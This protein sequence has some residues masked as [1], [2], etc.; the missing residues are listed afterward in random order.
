MNAE[1]R[2]PNRLI[3]EKSPYLHQ[4][5]YNPVDWYPWGEEAFEKAK[6]EN[7]PIFLSIGYSTC[8]WCH[9]MEEESFEDLKVAERLNEVFVCIKVD[10]EERPDIDQIY[11]NACQMMTG[12]GGW[13]LTIIM[14]PDKTPFF[15]G[16]YF[17]KKSKYGRIGLLELIERVQ[18]IWEHRRQDCVNA[19]EKITEALRQEPAQPAGFSPG[20]LQMKDAFLHLQRTFDRTYGG[21]GNAPK[22]PTVQNLFFLLR[23]WKTT[24]ESD[25][26]YMVEKTLQE[27]RKGG[28][29][30]HI[31]SGFHRYSTGRDW[32]L[33]HFEKMLYDQAMLAMV[34]CEAY[35][36]TEKCEYADT[37]REIFTY[38][39]R[40][41][42]SPLGGFFSAED[43]DSEGEEGKFYLWSLNEIQQILGAEEAE[44]F[45]KC[46]SIEMEGNFLEEATGRRTGKNI[47]YLL[48]SFRELASE[49]NIAESD[50]KERWEGWRE[51]LFSA[52]EK[53]IRPLKDEKILTDWNGLMIAA[54]SKG[55]KILEEPGYIKSAEKAAQFIFQHLS[56]PGGSLL[57]RYKDGEAGIPGNLNDYAFF[58][59]GL[60]ELYEASLDAR[61]L[62]STL[63]LTDYL[64]H[65]FWDAKSYG[66]YF[67]SEEVQ[68]VIVRPKDW[69]EGAIPSGNSVMYL[70]LLQLSRI[71]GNSDYEQRAEEIGFAAYPLIQ[72]IPQAFTQ[73]LCGVD[74][75]MGPTVEVVI[76]GGQDSEDVQ[77]M[78][79]HLR[80]LF[81][82]KKI[83]LFKPEE[84]PEEITEIA[85]FTRMFKSIE[86]KATAYVC[87]DRVCQRPTVEITE[88]LEFLDACEKSAP[89]Y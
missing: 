55:G 34:Y 82:P 9:V 13:P 62:K 22:F 2:K 29:Y 73:L 40:D 41:L 36:A 75:A 80:K 85:P 25:A 83:L 81:L 27:M 86:G 20:F 38:V 5:A 70:N 52:R 59:W 23:Y 51:K 12:T 78:L 79:C 8:H 74:F 60:L 28:V 48:R 56:G 66:F 19:S 71:T 11:M 49:W 50:L 43:A 46:F 53:R 45:A 84:N 54:L 30:D 65:H 16:T 47:P 58:I 88:M 44:V 26:L 3:G 57:H 1:G 7:K 77:A 6:R 18:E 72:Q 33:P 39:L 68:D 37:A 89:P 42:T 32:C 14:T 69:F 10:R 31:G 21:W 24:G 61:Y 63:Q 15:A 67:I 87:T 35:Q 64:L 4:H 17:P 76:A